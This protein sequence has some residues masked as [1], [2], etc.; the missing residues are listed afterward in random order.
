MIININ[1]MAAD[2][3]HSGG[4]N[5]FNDDDDIY[6]IFQDRSQDIL[7]ITVVIDIWKLKPDSLNQLWIFFSLF[8]SL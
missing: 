6:L 7:Y 4:G 8:L 2:E 5:G 1:K 3:N